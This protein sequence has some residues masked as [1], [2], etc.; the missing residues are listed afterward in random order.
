M[1]NKLVVF[2][3]FFLCLVFTRI[4]A[5]APSQVEMPGTVGEALMEPEL[6]SHDKLRQVHI[7]KTEAKNLV[8]DEAYIK[9]LITLTFN[10]ML[11]EGLLKGEKGDPGVSINSIDPDVV[12]FQTAYIPGAFV[13]P[14][15]GTVF[16]ATNLSSDVLISNSANFNSL[17]LS[18][19]L[20]V[21]GGVNFSGEASMATTSVTA[22]SVFTISSQAGAYLSEGGDWVNASSRELKEN[23]ATTSPNE[24]LEKI[25]NL[26][27]YSWNYKNQSSLITHTGP[28]AEDFYEIFKL[29]GENASTSISTIDTSGVA[30]LGIQALNEK[31][32]NLTDLGWILEVLKKLGVE[33]SESLVKAKNLV[34]DKISTKNLEVGSGELPTGITIYDSV[35]REPVCIFS[36]N[37]S[38]KL[39]LGKCGDTDVQKEE[40]E[41]LGTINA[42]GSRVEMHEL[43]ES[44]VDNNLSGEELNENIGVETASNEPENGSLETNVEKNIQ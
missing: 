34:A 22:L 44:S 12:G 20:S 38:L 8:I 3:I 39:H 31:I 41:N 35:T 15:V 36:E 5:A 18:G 23:L 19:D 29:G 14:D 4:I 25:A 37:V 7:T 30:L 21:E 9:N 24:I 16:A 28:M 27:I 1:K 26:P 11:S 6:V 13:G 40:R 32:K 33:I 2:L 43:T 17:E 42:E 10:Q